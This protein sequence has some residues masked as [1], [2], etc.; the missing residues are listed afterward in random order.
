[1]FGIFN[2]KKKIDE[3]KAEVYVEWA[4]SKRQE[5]LRKK[6]CK[7]IELQLKLNTLVICVSNEI[8]N[9]TVGVATKIIHITKAMEPQ[10]IVFDL[11]KKKEIMPFGVIFDIDVRKL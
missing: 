3:A 6:E 4:E 1:M 7:E 10:L 8:E 11:V 2:C 5:D 9:I